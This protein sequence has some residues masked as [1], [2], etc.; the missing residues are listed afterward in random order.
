MGNLDYSAVGSLIHGVTGDAKDDIE[1][2]KKLDDPNRWSHPQ[3]PAV[4][5]TAPAASSAAPVSSS[6]TPI[7]PDAQE[8]VATTTGGGPTPPTA[9]PVTPPV[10]AG[11]ATGGT[12][13]N[14]GGTGQPG[15]KVPLSDP[16]AMSNPIV[17]R[18]VTETESDPKVIAAFQSYH[19]IPDGDPQKGQAYNDYYKLIVDTFDSAKTKYVAIAQAQG[20]PLSAAMLGK[21]YTDDWRNHPGRRVASLP[22][23][24]DA[25]RA[26]IYN[27]VNR[28]AGRIYNAAA[29]T[30]NLFSAPED[31]MRI[32]PKATRAV[33]GAGSV[34][35]AGGLSRNLFA[36]TRDTAGIG[37]GLNMFHKGL[38]YAAEL[39]NQIGTPDEVSA[40]NEDTD[41]N[42]VMPWETFQQ[43]GMGLRSTLD[44][45]GNPA[46]MG[47][48][49]VIARMFGDIVGDSRKATQDASIESGRP[50]GFRHPI[51]TIQNWV[52]GTRKQ[53]NQA[54][55]SSDLHPSLN[56][57]KEFPAFAKAMGK[58][59]PSGISGAE[60]TGNMWSDTAESGRRVTGLENGWNHPLNTA[61]NWFTGQ[62]SAA[63]GLAKDW[64]NDTIGKHDASNVNSALTSGHTYAPGKTDTAD[65]QQR[66]QLAEQFR[67]AYDW[68]TYQSNPG[69]H[70]PAAAAASNSQRMSPDAAQAY[71]KKN[72]QQNQILDSFVN[73]TIDAPTMRARMAQVHQAMGLKDPDAIRR[74]PMW[75]QAMTQSMNQTRDF[76][77]LN[78]WPEKG[79]PYALNGPMLRVQKAYE[80]GDIDA[81][82]ASAQVNGILQGVTK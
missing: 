39:V 13:A 68:A 80:N 48:Q 73:G 57:I 28:V 47:L 20:Q 52:S 9:S 35:R 37:R 22:M 23:E 78:L 31:A 11:T 7:A 75:N 30:K 40:R 4:P 32:L 34:A 10:P 63:K 6:A 62:G 70:D 72:V 19:A 17:A 1:L 15:P 79:V 59:T 66:K 18:A 25:A 45:A 24:L 33:E 77:S 71:T 26:M 38:P 65:I 64:Y 76:G 53:I 42:M 56:P 55:Y 36:L 2:G 50:N 69:L 21:A 46:F 82:Q 29:W 12:P 74:Y 54:A 5:S 41:R 3:T 81:Q 14:G 60:L 44:T 16:S 8:P 61:A 27:P 58:E 51:N 67:N 43:N 49:G